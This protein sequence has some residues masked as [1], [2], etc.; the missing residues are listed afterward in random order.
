MTA[1]NPTM[2][3]II[4]NPQD[5]TYQILFPPSNASQNHGSQDAR[6]IQPPC[7]NFP[8]LPFRQFETLHQ[9]QQPQQ[10]HQHQHQQQQ[11]QQ[12]H[13]P[14]DFCVYI[15]FCFS[16]PPVVIKRK[17]WLLSLFVE[18]GLNI[19]SHIFRL[20]QHNWTDLQRK[21]RKCFSPILS[22]LRRKR[23]AVMS[24]SHQLV[25]GI[26]ANYDEPQFGL[27]SGSIVK[28]EPS[29]RRLPYLFKM[30]LAFHLWNSLSI[31][32]RVPKAN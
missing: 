25:S 22:F 1:S 7:Y 26:L 24:F 18:Q 8:F 3:R 2:I 4:L 31:A 27:Q 20:V 10:Q 17:S 21:K 11:Q 30:A 9:H 32:N 13:Q 14:S 28:P 5:L 6:N 19:S 23:E 16:P 12:Q 29:R 15:I